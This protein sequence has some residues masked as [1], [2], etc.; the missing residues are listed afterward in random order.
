[1][2]VVHSYNQRFSARSGCWLCLLAAVKRRNLQMLSTSVGPPG[3]LS[4]ASRV[5]VQRSKTFV[6]S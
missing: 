2:F 6:P 1:M 3:E 5:V 4:G